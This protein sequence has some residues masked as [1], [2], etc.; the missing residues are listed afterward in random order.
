MLLFKRIFKNEYINTIISKVFSVI[1][2]L[3]QS[4]FVAR[5]LGAELKGTSEYIS[6]VV[7]IGSIVIT[8][9]MHQAYPFFK[10]T[11][12]RESF[13]YDY[14]TAIIILYSL[15]FLFAA[16]ALFLPLSLDIKSIIIL[17]PVVGYANVVSYVCL[18]DNPNLKN[19]WWIITSIVD[20]ISIILL[21]FFATRSFFWAIYILMFVNLVRGI[22][23]TIVIKPRIRVRKETFMLFGKLLR[24]GFFPMLALLM[25]TLNYRIDVLMLKS[26]ESISEADIGVYSIGI[27]VAEKIVILPD[28][29]K[30]ILASKL[31][32]G[33]KEEEVAKVSRLCFFTSLLICIL[34]FLVGNW[35]ISFLY[36][37]EY[38]NSYSI[39]MICAAGA[40]SVGFF[41]LIAQ[42]NIVNK[43]QALNVLML[44]I[45][46][47][48]DVIFNLLFIPIW[49]IYG[50]ALATA[51]G[52]F[53]CGLVFVIW[54]CVHSKTSFGKMILIQREDFRYIIN[55]FR[56]G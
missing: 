39:M 42:Y 46:I 54:F 21:F 35:G 17:I 22:V 44:S 25:T 20:F 38:S 47:L 6:S 40:I 33:A 48:V 9:G 45:A 4:I 23:Y 29:L 7:S 18:I 37:G 11:M 41:K 26:F 30:G 43:R 34:F 52:N 56:K 24:F 10:K 8:F 51:I 19:F 49:G 31:S 14:T 53:V 27:M 16:G 50:A 28:T 15:Y 1:L 5:F 2:S 3:A 12:D 36:G 32:R 55:I 13:F